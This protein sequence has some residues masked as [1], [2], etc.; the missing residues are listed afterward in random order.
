MGR[1]D[2]SGRRRHHRGGGVGGGVGGGPAALEPRHHLLQVKVFV[3]HA[4]EVLLG[5]LVDDLHRHLGRELPQ[6]QQGG[7]IHLLLQHHPARVQRVQALGHYRREQLQRLGERVHYGVG[8]GLFLLWLLSLLLLSLLIGGG[9]RFFLIVRVRVGLVINI[10]EIGRIGG[11]FII[12]LQ[13]CS[14]VSL[15][16]VSRGINPRF[17]RSA[18]GGVVVAALRLLAIALVCCR[19]CTRALRE[20]AL[21]N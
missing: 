13:V 11:N 9:G 12:P 4:L 15:V 1:T 14:V 7:G 2:P 17:L 5:H 16:S 18:L 19:H 3:F 10:G 6:Q 8:V 20:A 21:V